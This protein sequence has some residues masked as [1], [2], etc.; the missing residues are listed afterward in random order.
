MYSYE[1]KLFILMERELFKNVY[2]ERPIKIEELSKKIKYTDGLFVDNT[3]QETNLIK[4]RGPEAFL[5][6]IKT[7]NTAIE[8]A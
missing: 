7:N 3:C 1:D 5:N 4:I 8:E 2:N 6:D